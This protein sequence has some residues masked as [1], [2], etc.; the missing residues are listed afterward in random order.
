MDE[1]QLEE[2]Q[3]NLERREALLHDDR[4][5][6]ELRGALAAARCRPDAIGDA[7]LLLASAAK[8]EFDA[9][10]RISKLAFGSEEHATSAAA[11]EAFMS[12]RAHW[13]TPIEPPRLVR[14][15]ASDPMREERD[16][17]SPP[18]YSP[19]DLVSR[20]WLKPPA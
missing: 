16:N 9:E 7:V 14:S 18:P 5:R 10:G 3:A 4:V 2:R 12:T 13:L 20:G 8:V 15:D 6:F 1:H 19:I 11:A 17:G